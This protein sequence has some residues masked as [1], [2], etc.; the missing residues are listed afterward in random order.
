[1]AAP[2]QPDEEELAGILGT[3]LGAWA[4]L[5]DQ[6]RDA[7][8]GI[9]DP[10]VAGHGGGRVGCARGGRDWQPWWL[11]EAVLEHAQLMLSIRQ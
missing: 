3:I 11:Q 5:E 9:V 8:D 7:E 4:D 2:L 6:A 1:M 10:S